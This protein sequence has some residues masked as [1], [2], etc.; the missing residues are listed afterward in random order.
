M[1]V[2]YTNNVNKSNTKLYT[3]GGMNMK[4]N[5]LLKVTESCMIISIYDSN[6]TEILYT[7]RVDDLL[8]LTDNLGQTV[9]S[10]NHSESDDY[11]IEI[12]I[13]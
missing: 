7:G 9:I 5:D 1:I 12:V 10:I 2:C 8:K 6:I 3:L 13:K 11:D 4:L